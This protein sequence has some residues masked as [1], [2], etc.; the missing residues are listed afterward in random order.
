MIE[1]VEG[2]Q[3]NGKDLGL[4]LCLREQ[5]IMCQVHVEIYKSRTRHSVACNASGTVVDNAIVIIVPPVMTLTGPSNS[6][7]RASLQ[8]STDISYMDSLKYSSSV[9]ARSSWVG[10]GGGLP[11]VS[12]EERSTASTTLPGKVEK[13]IKAHPGTGQPEKAQIGVEGADH[14]Y[15]EIRVPNRL[16]DGNGDKVKLKEG[17]EVEVTIEADPG[18][19][20][21]VPAPE[22]A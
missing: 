8:D 21:I 1:H 3:R 10:E 9:L 13:V 2:V 12:Q 7:K 11:V 20:Q 17:A 15:R 4:F 18:N 6:P 22:E 14:L 19:T 16:V 5:K